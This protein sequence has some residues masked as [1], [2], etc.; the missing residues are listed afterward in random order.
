M[1]G[2]DGVNYLLAKGPEVSNLL[3]CIYTGPLGAVTCLCIRPQSFLCGSLQGVISEYT[4]DV[5]DAT[6]HTLLCCWDREL[7]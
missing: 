1:L 4:L 2:E 6:L 3:Q 7:C 5:R